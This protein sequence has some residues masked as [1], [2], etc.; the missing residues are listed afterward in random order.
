M[1]TDQAQLK[2]S[3]VPGVNVLL[4]GASGTGKT[5]S[6]R[7]LIDAG[8]TPFVLSTE[9]GIAMTLGDI[10]ADKL[11]WHY[12]KPA[13]P[14]WEDLLGNAQKINTMSFETLTKLKDIDKQKYGQFLDLVSSCANFVC[15]RDGKSY[16]SVD[17]WGTD[18]C[19]VV[20]SLSGVNIMAMD[21]VAGAKPVK[22][23]GDWG[24]AMD[25]LERLIN[26]WTC[27]VDCHFVLI[28][29]M[30]R[31]KDEV[32]G[33]ITLTVSTLGQKLAPKIPRFFDDVIQAKHTSNEGWTW[34]T[35]SPMTD[36]KSRNLPLSEKLQPNFVP[37]IKSWQAK[38]GIIIPT[39]K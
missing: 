22:A 4:E 33:G 6:I 8:I 23:P 35:I 27:G 24:V 25:N 31:E 15:D 7:T 12:I 2:K 36:L 39:A 5:H 30:E 13:A 29:H 19:L 11:H 3:P 9:P 26:R 38:G 1:T 16:G 37:L 32:T 20:D 28:S 17:S 18:R 10:P 21:L 34:S 14:S